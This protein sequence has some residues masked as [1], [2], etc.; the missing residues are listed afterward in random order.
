MYVDNEISHNLYIESFA[1]SLIFPSEVDA[2]NWERAFPLYLSR[3][4]C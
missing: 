4:F 3:L 2:L 1:L